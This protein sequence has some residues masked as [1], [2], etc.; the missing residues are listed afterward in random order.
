MSRPLAWMFMLVGL[1]LASAASAQQ[2][3]VSERIG[4]KL[5]AA[6]ELMAA[7]Q[8][9]EASKILADINL[10][11]LGDYE[12]ALVHQFRG[13]LAI[14]ADDA[15]TA[16]RNFEKCLEIEALPP[17]GQLQ[18]RFNLAQ[19]YLSRQEWPKAIA[20][21][22]KWIRDTEEPNGVAYYMLAV[23][24]YQN[25]QKGEALAQ[26]RKALGLDEPA[27]EGWLSLVLSLL[28]EKGVYRESLPLLEELVERFPKKLYWQQLSAIYAELGQD[29]KSLAVQQLIYAQGM[30]EEER[31]LVRLSRMYLYH[32]LPYRAASVI[33][34]AIEDEIVPANAESLE[35][36]G[37][38]L[39]AAREFDRALEPMS[40]AARLS[41]KGDLWLRLGQ[42]RMERE[43]WAEAREALTSALEKGDLDDPGTAHLLLGIAA[44]N[45]QQLPA[46]RAAFRKAAKH[47]GTRKSANSW[48]RHVEREA[49]RA[50]SS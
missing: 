34:K 28:L 44:Y 9:A 21:L 43:D 27:R 22:Q 50:A 39:M 15:P 1:L 7:D 19:L 10:E 18:L 31:E 46:A 13:F 23:A 16:I 4:K 47:D 30:F 26:G 17:A 48:L 40:R 11:R 5:L 41:E 24:F 49:M 33:E 14:E 29:E 38:S 37:Q 2:Y 3:T 45:Q 8:N 25:E 36:L 12:Q 20:N 35:L 32:D 42:I 6:Q